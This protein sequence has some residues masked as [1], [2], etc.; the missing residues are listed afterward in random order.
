MS[1][2]KRSS[3]FSLVL[4]L[5]VVAAATSCGSLMPDKDFEES[6]AILSKTRKTCLKHIKNKPL[7]RKKCF[8]LLKNK[9]ILMK[10]E[11]ID[12]EEFFGS[13]SIHGI[14][15]T[16][17]SHIYCHPGKRLTKKILKD[18]NFVV[19]GSKYLVKGEFTR[20]S[21]G[22]S[23]FYT[24]KNCKISKFP[25]IKKTPSKRTAD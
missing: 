13:L 23:D 16:G 5:F 9:E 1:F 12:E 24:L 18:P 4:S 25:P 22:Y 21:S 17:D 10:V 7:A 19:I 3:V 14:S 20:F 6:R 15:G 2:P 11:E 8:P